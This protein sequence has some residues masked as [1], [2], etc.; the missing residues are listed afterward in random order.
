MLPK[1]HQNQ[2]YSQN[3]NQFPPNLNSKTHTTAPGKLGQKVDSSPL[4]RLICDIIVMDSNGSNGWI[5]LVMRPFGESI[6]WVFN[7]YIIPNPRLGWTDEELMITF[8]RLFFLTSKEF[9]HTCCLLENWLFAMA[10]FIYII[11]II[12]VILYS[13]FLLARRTQGALQ[14][15]LPRQTC[16]FQCHLNFLGSI[17]M[18]QAC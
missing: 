4:P 13:A 5:P 6:F 16:T 11:I 8:V 14:S 10:A 17:R 3:P 15:I 1:G 18:P 9:M 2:W 12:L 7:P